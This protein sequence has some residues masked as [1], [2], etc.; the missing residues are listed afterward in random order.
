[1]PNPLLSKSPPR[2]ADT[3]TIRILSDHGLC[4][5]AEFLHGDTR[6]RLERVD[7]DGN[8]DLRSLRADSLLSVRNPDGSSGRTTT[9]WMRTEYGAGR[10][11]AIGPIP[12]GGGE[13]QARVMRLTTTAAHLTSGKA[14]WR[15]SLS[16]RATMDAV[17]KTDGACDHW[18]AAH[19]GRVK[20]DI[21]HPRPSGSSLRRWMRRLE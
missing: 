16:R 7:Q 15:K 1:M 20:G 17:K 10:L 12:E 21:A 6:V 19:F 11:T 3:Q 8:A 4:A 9:E 18:L 14:K 13:R 2:G 5:G